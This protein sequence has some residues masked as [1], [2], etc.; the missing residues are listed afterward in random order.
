MALSAHDGLTREL[1]SPHHSQVI[2][3]N[4]LERVH[5]TEAVLAFLALGDA[6]GD[7]LSTRSD[8]RLWTLWCT[9]C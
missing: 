9:L 6:L 3:S 2:R 5:W 7:I 1:S 4:L 8:T